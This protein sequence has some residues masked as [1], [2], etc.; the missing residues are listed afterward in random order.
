[1]L[2]HAEVR[3]RFEEAA[4]KNAVFENEEMSARTSFRIGGA[5]ALFVTPDSE[6]SAVEVIRI[7]RESGIPYYVMGN[8]SNLLVADCGFD[9]AVIKLA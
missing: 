8:G 1:M 5:A 4:G 7:A 6:E 3:R 2:H 9:G